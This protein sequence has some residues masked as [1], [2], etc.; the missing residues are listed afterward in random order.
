MTVA[1]ES[2]WGWQTKAVLFWHE[3]FHCGIKKWCSFPTNWFKD[4]WLKGHYS[5][6][7]VKITIEQCHHHDFFLWLDLQCFA[8]CW[9]TCWI[10]SFFGCC[11]SFLHK[12]KHGCAQSSDMAVTQLTR[13]IPKHPLWDV[14][15]SEAKLLACDWW[16]HTFGAGKKRTLVELDTS[17]TLFVT[18]L[19][20][21]IFAKMILAFASWTINVDQTHVYLTLM[22]L[23]FTTNSPEHLQFLAQIDWACADK[24]ENTNHSWGNS[25]MEQG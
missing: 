9:I 17:K 25:L 23:I 5:H 20:K 11:T 19:M 24:T 4:D 10:S 18:I 7:K 1:P 21:N 16:V 13:N 14:Q 15:I 22:N 8:C 3:P 6:F 2:V 12:Y